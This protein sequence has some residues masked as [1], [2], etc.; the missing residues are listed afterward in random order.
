MRNNGY[1]A[2]LES[3]WSDDVVME[4][5]HFGEYRREDYPSRM[6]ILDRDFVP[7]PS[8][9]DRLVGFLEGEDEG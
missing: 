8:L 2:F 9:Y 5:R 1:L 4:G 3:Y 6:V 7:V